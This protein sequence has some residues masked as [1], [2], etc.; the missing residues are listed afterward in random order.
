M[1]E[2]SLYVDLTSTFSHTHI[3][4]SFIWCA[5]RSHEEKELEIESTEGDAEQDPKA[6]DVKAINDPNA[7]HV[8]DPVE[9][10]K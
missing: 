3:P 7:P 8:I 6:D 4:H 1:Y 9:I 5:C 10:G 2:S